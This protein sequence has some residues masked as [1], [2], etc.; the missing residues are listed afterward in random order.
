MKRAG[1]LLGDKNEAFR[2]LEISYKGRH[3]FLPWINKNPF[4]APLHDDPRFQD[5]VRRINP[6]R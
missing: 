6:P 3:S 5:L 2:W 1:S 4:Y